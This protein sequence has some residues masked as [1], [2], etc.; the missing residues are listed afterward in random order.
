MSKASYVSR[1][2][3]EETGSLKSKLLYLALDNGK[4]KGE[5]DRERSIDGFV[6]VWGW[7]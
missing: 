2:L 5:D 7:V 1:L 3:Y 6:C 4:G